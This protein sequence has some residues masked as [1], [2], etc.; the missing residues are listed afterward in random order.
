MF[1]KCLLVDFIQ[2][3]LVPMRQHVFHDYSWHQNQDSTVNITFSF[4]TSDNNRFYCDA[5]LCPP[6]FH[7]LSLSSFTFSLLLSIFYFQSFTFS[8]L[9]S[10]F[11]FQ[12]FAVFYFQSFTFNLLLSIFCSLL[13]LIFYFQSF[14]FNLL[15]SFTFRL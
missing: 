15:Q 1:R 14:T 6:C 5:L 2:G 3:F 10:I 4:L 13:L 11:Y 12:S 8:L 7:P 9:I